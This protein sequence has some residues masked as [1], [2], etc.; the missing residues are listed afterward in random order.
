MSCSSRF[1]G[2]YFFDFSRA[3]E[4]IALTLSRTNHQIARSQ[5]W[6][7]VLTVLEDPLH[8]AGLRNGWLALHHARR[9]CLRRGVGHDPLPSDRLVEQH[10][11]DGV[12][13]LDAL[14]AQRF[15]APATSMKLRVEHV[16]VHRS[17]RSKLDGAEARD[18][19]LP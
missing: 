13:V 7:V 10:S 6:V 16:D 17:D 4:Q 5:V 14:G 2:A 18:E 9:T 3:D 15:D 8:V 19:T 1:C 12:D 11:Q